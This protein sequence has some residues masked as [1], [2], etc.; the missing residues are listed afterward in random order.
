M[1]FNELPHTALRTCHS[2]QEYQE[3]FAFFKTSSTIASF[4]YYSHSAFVRKPYQEYV[5]QSNLRFKAEG[6]DGCQ[7]PQWPLSIYIF[8]FSR[9]R[10][11]NPR[12]FDL[13][14]CRLLIPCSCP[15]SY[16]CKT[17]KLTDHSTDITQ[18]VCRESS[19]MTP[20][21]CKSGSSE[22]SVKRV[23]RTR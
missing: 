17:L 2:A 16:Q 9:S 5:I 14:D 1:K 23:I 6:Y 12:T 4:I 22:H 7:G 18:S 15:M 11:F 13:M 19:P 21:T 8:V 20:C 3:S 10:S